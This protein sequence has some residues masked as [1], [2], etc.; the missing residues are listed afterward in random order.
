MPANYRTTRRDETSIQVRPSA[1][2]PS[3]PCSNRTN[4][5]RTAPP[6][7]HLA[8]RQTPSRCLRARRGFAKRAAVADGA[9][10]IGHDAV[11]GRSAVLGPCSAGR[12]R[13]D[14]G[15][16]RKAVDLRE[17]GID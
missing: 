3:V 9:A 1:A 11:P 4:P 16:G 15:S 14:A 8:R 7:G 6:P 17:A 5:T 2:A 13:F 10:L 12:R